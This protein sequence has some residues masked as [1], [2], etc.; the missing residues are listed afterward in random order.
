MLTWRT[1]QS[2]LF[3]VWREKTR[4]RGK[5]TREACSALLPHI[6]KSTQPQ[7]I[8]SS[9]SSSVR[10]GWNVLF[11]GISPYT[12]Q[13]IHS[14]LIGTKSESYFVTHRLRWNCWT[15]SIGCCEDYIYVCWQGRSIYALACL[16]LMSGNIDWDRSMR[17]VNGE[18]NL[19]TIIIIYE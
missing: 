19:C 17:K 8:T 1:G 18:V 9:S 12:V 11:W 3:F 10:L 2:G 5:L 6:D 4:N 15:C 16:W 7:Y 13:Y 14:Q